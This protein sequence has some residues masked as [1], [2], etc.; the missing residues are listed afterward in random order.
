MALWL[1]C[2]DL[3]KKMPVDCAQ[4]A[5]RLQFSPGRQF[6]S[7]SAHVEAKFRDKIHKRPKHELDYVLGKKDHR[8][9][10]RAG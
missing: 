6:S 10:P 4:I 8:G 1:L 2:N 5:S 9:V 3:L 7:K